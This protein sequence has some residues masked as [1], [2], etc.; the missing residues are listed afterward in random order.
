MT[1]PFLNVRPQ[2]IRLK[3]SPR[4]PADVVGGAGIDVTKQNGIFTFDLD[5][6][7]FPQ[8]S[9]LPPNATY[10]LIFD[11]ITGTYVQ[12]PISLLG[13][14]DAPND[15]QLYGRKSATAGG[16]LAWQPISAGGA[17]TSVFGRTGAVVAQ[18]NDYTFAQIGAKPTTLGGY[19]ITDAWPLPLTS[20]GA[21]ANFNA[22]TT[23][24]H[25][26]TPDAAATNTPTSGHYWYLD[27]YST[28]PSQ[29]VKQV[30]TLYEVGGAATYIRTMVAGIW[31]AWNL[32]SGRL[33]LQADTTMYFRNDGDDSNN[34]FGNVSGIVPYPGN[35]AFKTIQALYDNIAATLDLNGKQVT[36]RAGVAGDTFAAG[37]V[38][39]QPWTGGGSIVFDGNGGTINSAGAEGITNACTLPGFLYV[40]SVTLL[41][42]GGSAIHNA[43]IGTIYINP[44]VG[45]GSCAGYHMIAD[46]PGALITVQNIVGIA[47]T[48]N[49]HICAGAGGQIIEAGKAHSLTGNVVLQS[50]SQAFAFCDRTSYIYGQSATYPLGAFTVTG[51]GLRYW[52]ASNGVINTAGGGANVYPGANPGVNGGSGGQYI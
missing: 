10:A 7:D 6:T 17:V 5:Y 14:P 31:G 3:V 1:V 50:A 41:A 42:G 11:P 27:V 46:K 30:A 15:T 12:A 24:G 37:F 19:G 18:A 20:T 25:Y 28:N 36:M 49:G 35:G 21:A 52:V 34:G 48:V 39:R 43:S 32:Q 33:R 45:F 22:I 2:S 23:N 47:G 44:G 29:Y 13:F 51:P 26:F 4:F 16:P 9:A 8:I 40:G 38:A